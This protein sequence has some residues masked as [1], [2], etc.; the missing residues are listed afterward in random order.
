MLV[1]GLILMIFGGLSLVLPMIGRQ[2]IIFSRL[3]IPE[4]GSILMLAIGAFLFYLGKKQEE[5]E[6]EKRKT[7][8]PLYMMDLCACPNCGQINSIKN[9]TCK[10]C[11]KTL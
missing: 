2:F 8:S 9:K 6:R 1:W 11:S 7:N 4:T 3:G 5:E 10:T